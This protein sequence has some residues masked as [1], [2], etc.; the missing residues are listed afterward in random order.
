MSLAL[1]APASMKLLDTVGFD[2][3]SRATV[4]PFRCR[5]QESGEG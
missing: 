2:K 3:V 5:D 1:S 4:E